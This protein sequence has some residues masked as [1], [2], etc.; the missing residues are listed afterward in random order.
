MGC[1]VEWGPIFSIA[2]MH[3]AVNCCGS[4]EVRGVQD[5]SQEPS[6]IMLSAIALNRTSSHLSETQKTQ[7][8]HFLY[9][10][11]KAQ[12]AWVGTNHSA[13]QPATY[14]LY[15]NAVQKDFTE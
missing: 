8:I 5:A 13:K 2:L 15:I 10:C 3:G 1:G 11:D 7:I 4:V 14:M 12:R 6:Y 9:T